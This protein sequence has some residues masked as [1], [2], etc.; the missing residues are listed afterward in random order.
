MPASGSAASILL[1]SNRHTQFHSAVRILPTSFRA[2]IS[3]MIPMDT[4]KTRLVTQTAQA[5]VVPYKGVLRTLTRIVKEEGVGPIYRSLT[6]RLVS[7]VPMI[8]IQ[9]RL[10]AIVL[11]LAL[12]LYAF[13]SMSILV[14][15]VPSYSL[16]VFVFQPHDWAV[17]KREL[18]CSSSKGLTHP[19]FNFRGKQTFGADHGQVSLANLEHRVPPTI[20]GGRCGFY[21]HPVNFIVEVHAIHTNAPRLA[22]TRMHSA[23]FGIYEFVR[24]EIMSRKD[25]GQKPRNWLPP[26]VRR[27]LGMDYGALQQDYF[28]D[29]LKNVLLMEEELV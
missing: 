1:C 11:P 9:V 21:Q 24:K 28:K 27:T 6:P 14:A 8:G 3:I 26:A 4:V 13:L 25:E 19:I 18:G 20:H 29:F 7:V 16:E 10:G 12:C 23:Q 5:G 22:L 15:V 2:A 17:T